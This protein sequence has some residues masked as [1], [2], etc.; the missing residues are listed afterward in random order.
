[1]IDDSQRGGILDA[2]DDAITRGFDVDLISMR[3]ANLVGLFPRWQMAVTNL[4]NKMAAQ[5]KKQKEIDYR[6]AR[7]SDWLR[8]RRG[9]MIA[10][11]E[12]MTAM[13]T[14]RMNGWYQQ[15]EMG[16]LDPELSIK[17]WSSSLDACPVCAALNGTSVQGIE[18]TF[19]AGQFGKVKAGPA[20]PSCRCV[21]LI[22]PVRRADQY[23]PSERSPN[24]WV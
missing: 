6:T 4:G 12:L 3:I 15:S 8:E 2:L 5:G 14:G 11:T 10:R 1:M 20:H 16:L 22:H 23:L 17:E 19:D 24:E 21:V 13:N 7:Y 18:G 9:I